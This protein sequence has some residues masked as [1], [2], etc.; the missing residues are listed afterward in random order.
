M[1]PAEEFEPLV[2]LHDRST[3]LAEAAGYDAE[4]GPGS[5]GG[6]GGRGASSATTTYLH[7]FTAVASI[8]GFLFGFD[9]GVI[10]GALPYIRDDI[11]QAKYA[12]DAAALAHWQEVGGA[13]Q[14]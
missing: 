1:L 13:G 11:L 12:G 8:G 4:L 10:S 3:T 9:T 2:D 5:D 14:R 7:I 6:G